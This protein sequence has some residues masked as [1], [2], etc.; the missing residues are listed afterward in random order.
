MPKFSICFVRLWWLGVAWFS[1]LLAYC[2]PFTPVIGNSPNNEDGDPLRIIAQKTYSN[3]VAIAASVSGATSGT[4]PGF[5]LIS[6]GWN[7]SYSENSVGTWRKPPFYLNSFD[8][9]GG[10]VNSGNIAQ[11]IQQL[12]NGSKAFGWNTIEIDDGW[13]LAYPNLPANNL[14]P[15]DTVKFPNGMAWEVARAHTNGLKLWIYTELG[16]NTDG[17]FCGTGTNIVGNAQMFAS[18]GVDGMIFH[19]APAGSQ[20]VS[21]IISNELIFSSVLLSNNPGMF[22]QNIFITGSG[23]NDQPYKSVAGKYFS[24]WKPHNTTAFADVVSSMS[25]AYAARSLFLTNYDSIGNGHFLCPLNANI[26]AHPPTL[27]DTNIVRA[28]ETVN[29]MF[30]IGLHTGSAHTSDSA[31][32]EMQY[33]FLN[34]TVCQ[35]AADAYQVGLPFKTTITAT[36]TN[37]VWLKTLSTGQKA[38]ALF[39]WDTANSA[40]VSFTTNDIGIGSGIYWNVL[41]GWP[42]T[43]WGTLGFSNYSATLAPNESRLLLL[44]PAPVAGNAWAVQIQFPDCYLAGSAAVASSSYS[45]QQALFCPANNQPSCATPLPFGLGYYSTVSSFKLEGYTD[46]ANNGQINIQCVS[47]RVLAT[48]AVSDSQPSFTTIITNGVQFATYTLTNYFLDDVSPRTLKLY[49]TKDGLADNIT[50]RVY[51]DQWT[52][53][54]F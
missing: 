47:Y 32:P 48:G 16:S 9:W 45:A 46:S 10:A 42:N 49:I 19:G 50:N 2:Q 6:G 33:F 27:A 14:V 15:T 29:A 28:T 7:S 5:S 44:T 38:V 26:S 51:I 39:N 18:W 11:Y 17:G 3:E 24:A 40:T 52:V 20:P 41:D 35:V 54:S 13:Q 12:T 43:N 30:G 53:K 1:C 4:S 23:G 37:E 25:Q 36:G 21:Q 8:G 22:L 34:P 31:Y